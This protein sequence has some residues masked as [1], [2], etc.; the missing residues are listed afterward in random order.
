MMRSLLILVAI[1]FSA[2]AFAQS[3]PPKVGD[4]LLVQVKSK[5][6]MGCKLIGTVRGTKLN[7]SMSKYLPLCPRTR[8]LLDPVGMSQRC[9]L[10]DS[11]TAANIFCCERNT[12]NG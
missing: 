2:T 7:L 12:E 1:C 8:T 5:A 3:A 10:S 6:P 11:C 4:K 9:P